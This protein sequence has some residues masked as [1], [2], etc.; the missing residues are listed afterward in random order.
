M[1]VEAVLDMTSLHV[2]KCVG[3]GHGLVGK[4]SFKIECNRQQLFQHFRAG[5]TSIRAP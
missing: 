1:C 5:N 3:R 4:T 2:S